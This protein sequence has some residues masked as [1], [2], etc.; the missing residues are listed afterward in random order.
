[1]FR[2]V[3]FLIAMIAF[4]GSA[5]AQEQTLETSA[6]RARLAADSSCRKSEHPDLRMTQFACKSGVYSFTQPNDGLPVGYVAR[7]LV[8]TPDGATAIRTSARHEGAET[9]TS[10]FYNWMKAIAQRLE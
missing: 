8:E 4:A 6:M 7:E 3:P 10:V 5:V 2:G 1:M 9:D